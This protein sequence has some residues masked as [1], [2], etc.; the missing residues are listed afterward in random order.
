MERLLEGEDRLDAQVVEEALRSREDRRDLERDVHRDE[1]VLLEDLGEALAAASLEQKLDPTAVVNDYFTKAGLGSN[2]DGVDVKQGANFRI[3]T[4]D[5]KV[6]SRNY[7]MSLLDTPELQ[8]TAAS[9]AEQRITNVEI[10]LVLDVSGS[11]YNSISRIT[12]L[13]VAAKDFVDTVLANDV[14]CRAECSRDACT[15]R[16]RSAATRAPA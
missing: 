16:R 2:I 9:T 1:D 6:L 15:R 3:I 7:F 13:K 8:G 4:A 10:A 5:A 14:E 12:N 11:M